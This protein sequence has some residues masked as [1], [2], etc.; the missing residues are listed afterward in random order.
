MRTE[1]VVNHHHLI[2]RSRRGQ[3]LPSNL[4]LIKVMRHRNW[5]KMWQNRTLLEIIRLLELVD[6]KKFHPSPQWKNIFGNKTRKEGLYLLR[7]VYRIKKSQE[8]YILWN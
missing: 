6:D 5:H 3:D 4:L 8:V 2:P 7:R 1:P